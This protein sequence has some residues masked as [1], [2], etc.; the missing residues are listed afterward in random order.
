MVSQGQMLLMLGLNPGWSSRSL[1]ESP[2]K[3][4]FIST[5]DNSWSK[6]PVTERKL[7][8][9]EVR[10]EQGC[11]RGSWTLRTSS[12]QLP[13]LQSRST[14]ADPQPAD[15]QM[16]G[17]AAVFAEAGTEAGSGLGVYLKDVGG[18]GAHTLRLT[19]PLPLQPGSPSIPLCF[20]LS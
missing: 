5:S 18:L 14:H 20:P 4:P 16:H 7:H 8:R 15:G 19:R 10:G 9:S 12:Q 1:E 3:V 17:R 11:S 6:H 2:R 13:Q